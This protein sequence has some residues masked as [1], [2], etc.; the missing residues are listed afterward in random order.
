MMNNCAFKTFEGKNTQIQRMIV[1][2]INN[3]DAIC[4]GMS[5]DKL[6][7]K[8]AE[9]LATLIL[10]CCNIGIPLIDQTE[11]RDLYMEQTN[12]PYQ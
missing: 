4:P 9:Y 11:I 8:C 12:K 1:E 2:D 7:N 6:A 3:K 5:V 10:G